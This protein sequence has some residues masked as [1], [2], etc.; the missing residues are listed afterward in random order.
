V[1]PYKN[2]VR[3]YA[4]R[5]FK[6]EEYISGILFVAVIQKTKATNGGDSLIFCNISV[7]FSIKYCNYF[8]QPYF[9]DETTL[10][11]NDTTPIDLITLLFI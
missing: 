7:E 8:N 1:R 10:V 11:A 5:I 9:S 4:N 6:Y 3:P 2:A